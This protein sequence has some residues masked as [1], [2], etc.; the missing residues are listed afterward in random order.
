MLA[1]RVEDNRHFVHRIDADGH[2]VF[3]NTDWLDFATENGWPV[4]SANLIGSPLSAYIADRETQHLYRLIIDTT[5]AHRRT[6][7]F[8]YRCDSPDCRRFL[9]MSI[10]HDQASDTVEFRSRVL[11][12]EPRPTVA[13]LEPT[14]R[15]RSSDLL[16]LCG[17]CK[18]AQV[19]DQWVEVEEAVRRL[20]LFDRKQLPLLSHGICPS[21]LGSLKSEGIGL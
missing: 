8:N 14:D 7:V 2:I 21:C 9:E 15:T 3:V 18:S 17:W 10:H 20:R 13:L 11:R 19:D 12:L 5:R 1:Q 16:N 6:V 4:S